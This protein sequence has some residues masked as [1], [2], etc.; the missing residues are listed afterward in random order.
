MN[1]AIKRTQFLMS[2]NNKMTLNENYKKF[3]DSSQPVITDWLS[4]DEKYFIFLDELY[5]LKN[6]TKLGNI[7]ENFDRFKIFIKHS[8]EV[9]K[10]VP[11][12]IR[13]SVLASLSN[14]LLLESKQ[15]YSPLKPLIR[16]FLSERTWGEWALETGKDFGGW[17][18]NKGAEAVK[19]VTDFATTTYSNA[20]K[21]LG[22]ISRGEWQEALNL[23]AQGPLYIA[24]RLRD[25]MYHPIGMI[26]DIILVVTEIGKLPQAVIWAIIVALDIYEIST[27]DTETETN[28]IMQFIMLGIDIIGLVTSGG[29]A[30]VAR[31]M[32][33]G[34]RT[35]GELTGLV[36]K[37]PMARNTLNQ[38]AQGAAKTPSLLKS[39]AESLSRVFPM[40]ESFIKSILGSLDS[41]LQK[42]LT[43]I[44]KILKP[45]PVV[46]TTAGL[47]AFYGVEKGLEKGAEAVTP[48]FASSDSETTGS[49]EEFN[50]ILM[51]GEADYEV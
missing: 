17:V 30:G 15:N 37:N 16:Q 28:I 7:W 26:L 29:I 6:K 22:N 10:N 27:G 40:G 21:L 23:I 3:D 4:P 36:S 50:K 35:I 1:P 38:M 2:Y 51:S 33:A 43:T 13:E 19:G 48:L 46:A 5:D 39:A 49:D 34:V 18:Y 20:K 24:R 42:F 44:G 9:A 32:F 31:E 11:E 14:N 47:G 8:F 45:K 41:V 25:F 12:N